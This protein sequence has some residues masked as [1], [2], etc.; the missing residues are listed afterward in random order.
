MPPGLNF[1]RQ[2]CLSQSAE[3]QTQQVLG[4]RWLDFS[5]SHAFVLVGT[6]WIYL[7]DFTVFSSPFLGPRFPLP[8]GVA[9]M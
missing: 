3:A 1:G 7:S 6:N 4:R 5:T 9:P 2:G 8:D